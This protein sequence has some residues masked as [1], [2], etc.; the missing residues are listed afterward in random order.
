MYVYVSV[1]IHPEIRI[2]IEV[3]DLAPNIYRVLYSVDVC[4]PAATSPGMDIAALCLSSWPAATVIQT[5][6]VISPQISSP[7][8]FSRQ[9]TATI[10]MHHSLLPWTYMQHVVLDLYVTFLHGSRHLTKFCL[11][12]CHWAE[13][14][15]KRTYTAY[16]VAYTGIHRPPLDPSLAHLHPH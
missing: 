8:Q 12:A 1:S 11:G 7:G 5:L 13:P 15:S 16:I 10:C 14:I 2:R 9:L 6:S 3:S 4:I